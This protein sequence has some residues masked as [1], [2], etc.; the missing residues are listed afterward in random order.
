MREQLGSGRIADIENGK[1][2]V[3][4]GAIGKVAGDE[5]VMQGITA[6]F[7]PTR[8]LAAACPHAGNPPLT[9][10]LGSGRLCHVDDRQHLVAE[11]GVVDRDVGVTAADIPDAMRPHPLGRHKGELARRLGL[12]DVV[13]TNPGR[14]LLTLQKIG[15]RP[16]VM[17]LRIDLHR[18]HARPVNGEQQIVMGLEVDRAGVGRARHEGNGSRVLRVAHIDDADAIR[19]AMA[20]I[21]VAAMHHDLDAVAAPTLVGVADELDVAGR[22]RIHGSPL[23]LFRRSSSERI[24][25]PYHI[26]AL[27]AT[28]AFVKRAASPWKS[29]AQ[30]AADASN[31]RPT[32]L[33]KPAWRG[34]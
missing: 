6:A 14:V 17:G 7:G 21:G 13:N 25:A 10:D 5:R 28:T 22:D 8:C 15:R 3:A 2:A 31:A 11:L 23:R 20:D 24:E 34:R 27:A 1:S 30:S 33:A 19:I 16:R 4:P 29:G 32:E 18:P 9:D 26:W 12:R